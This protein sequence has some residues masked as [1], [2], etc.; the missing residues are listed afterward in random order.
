MRYYSTWDAGTWHLTAHHALADGADRQDSPTQGYVLSA[1]SEPRTRRTLIGGPGVSGLN[2]PMT[3]HP[4]LGNKHHGQVAEVSAALP[5][6]D[7]ARGEGHD[8]DDPPHLGQALDQ[9]ATP[10]LPLVYAWHTDSGCP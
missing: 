7:E 4:P 8:M 5:R 2:K 6:M 10:A 3:G 9:L 1:V